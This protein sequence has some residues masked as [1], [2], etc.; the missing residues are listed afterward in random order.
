MAEKRELPL[1]IRKTFAFDTPLRSALEQVRAHNLGTIVVLGC[2]PCEAHR[3][4]ISS[5][6]AGIIDFRQDWIY[7]AAKGEGATILAADYGKIV[8]RNAILDAPRDPQIIQSGTRHQAAALFAPASGHPVAVISK[9]RETFTLFYRDN[10]YDFAKENAIRDRVKES[11]ELLRLLKENYP[12]KT[13][14]EYNRLAEGRLWERLADLL[15][16]LTEMGSSGQ[17]FMMASNLLLEQLGLG[18]P[19]PGIDQAVR[20]EQVSV[21][22]PIEADRANA[23]IAIGSAPTRS[24]ADPG[25]IVDRVEDVRSLRSRLAEG[26]WGVRV[27]RGT[28]G[29]GKTRIVNEVLQSFRDEGPTSWIRHHTVN[30]GSRL[31]IATLIDLVDGVPDRVSRPGKSSLVRL[32]EALRRLQDTRVVVIVDA[33]EKLLDPVTHLLLDADLDEA[34]EMVATVRGHRLTILLV[35]Q[36]EPK[37]PRSSTWSAPE[38]VASVDKLPRED[39]F[40][41]LRSLGDNERCDG[42]SLSED[43]WTD[44]YQQLQGNPRLGELAHAVVLLS[45][46]GSDL[47]DLADRLRAVDTREAPAELVALL[48]ENTNPAQR[49]VLHALA[50]FDTPVPVSSIVAMA[51][52]DEPGLGARAL[53][54]LVGHRIVYQ[55]SEGTYFLPSADCD[56]VMDFLPMSEQ[57]VLYVRASEELTLLR[58]RDPRHVE[59]LRVHFAELDA[60]IRADE[61]ASAY[62]VLENISDF[63]REWNCAHLLLDRRE[64]LAGKLGDDHLE[65]AN[66]ND[67]A[68]LYLGQ[69]LHDKA[70]ATLERATAIARAQN[71]DSAVTAMHSNLAGFY[72]AINDVGRAQGYFELALDEARGLHAPLALMVAY[73]GIAGCHR[74]L[75]EFEQALVKAQAALDVP[76]LADFEISSAAMAFVESLGARIT[77]KMA[78]WSAEQ[79]NTTQASTLVGSLHKAAS[80]HDDGPLRAEFLDGMAD[81]T[82]FHGDKKTAE[83]YAL[84]AVDVALRRRDAFVLLQARTTLCL[85]YLQQRR[86]DHARKEIELARPFRN[87]GQSLSVLALLALTAHLK[88]DR[89]AATKYFQALLEESTQRIERERRDFAAWDMRGLALCGLHVLTPEGPMD[90]SSAFHTARSIIGRAAPGHVKRVRFLIEQLGEPAALD[91]FHQPH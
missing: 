79:G 35:T 27:L 78:R 56:F 17:R 3:K 37:S 47:A 19:R 76:V 5:G 14:E 59:D 57:E 49:A 45:D 33:A 21:A 63:L 58:S 55:L 26:P 6:D 60:L 89:R 65:K 83:Q 16:D 1:E 28:R 44:L 11:I 25:K 70:F 90:A 53:S 82:L 7:R 4:W 43:D 86:V 72:L 34:L 74:R 30:A 39:F 75:G 38:L 13:R 10:E 62:G 71:H 85:S 20:D 29:I 69:G 68:D 87:K 66:L 2:D 23:F 48:L 61:P 9:S 31:D 50:A 64:R 40:K 77:L 12:T 67:L 46:H 41:Y 15:G 91:A 88:R 42:P 73:E 51:G 18:W 32:E 24:R 36:D 81:I 80:V 52:V 8:L 84:M 54:D 22:T